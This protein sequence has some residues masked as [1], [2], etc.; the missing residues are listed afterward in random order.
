MAAY[1]KKMEPSIKTIQSLVD[2]D[3]IL[4][5]Y[6]MGNLLANSINRTLAIIDSLQMD[7]KLKEILKTNCYYEMLQ[8]THKEALDSLINK[9]KQKFLILPYRLMY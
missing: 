7:E 6:M 4:N 9:S 3:E 2:R 8:Q 1:N 5:E